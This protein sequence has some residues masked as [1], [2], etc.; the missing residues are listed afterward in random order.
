MAQ[1]KPSNFDFRSLYSYANNQAGSIKAHTERMR[2]RDEVLP[3]YKIPLTYNFW[4]EDYFLGR[5]STAGNA[6]R[7]DESF[8]K[9]IRNAS[10][11]TPLFLL[12]FA[13]DA[14]RDFSDRIASLKEDGV[15][16]PTGP[17]ADLTA[18]KA[19]R[20]TI[21]DYHSYM[22][23]D[24]YP[25]FANLYLGVFKNE[26]KSIL[27]PNSFLKSFG[28]FFTNF[29]MELGPLSL[30]GFI[31]SSKCSPFNSG[32]VVDTS[33][34]DHSDDFKKCRKFLLDENFSLVAG[35]ASEYGFAIDE[36]AP[37]RF[38]ADIKS[39]AMREYMHGVPIINFPIDPLNETDNCFVPIIPEG[40]A[41]VEPYG[42]SQIEGLEDVVRHAPGYTAY[43]SFKLRTH[44]TK[45]FEGLY[46]TA[47][48]ECWRNDMDI[49]R[50]YLHDFYNALVSTQPV[51]SVSI[52]EKNKKCLTTRSELVSRPPIEYL[53]FA[54][55]GSFGDKWNLKSYYMIRR[56]EKSRQESKKLILK[57]LRETLNIYDAGPP[58]GG[59]AK[60]LAALRHLQEEVIGPTT[61][62]DLTIDTVGDILKK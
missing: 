5:I 8:L 17:Y 46:S 26:D 20:S 38:V 3:E 44:T 40:Y 59:D 35:I 41:P 18:K 49:I 23:D 61:A 52:V 45:V 51:V 28:N 30:S 43:N 58:A 6:T 62:D 24:I 47:F 32:L 16:E 2:Y 19:F 42:F 10:A 60:Y 33:D 4:G 9:P 57:N 31:E 14:W 13:A 39:P 27:D 12:N 34:D 36:N 55:N 25:I 50:I 53:D 1:T 21:T 11:D 54:R 15:L 22:V 7:V 48:I 37:W 29:L 56:T